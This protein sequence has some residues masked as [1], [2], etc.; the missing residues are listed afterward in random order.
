MIERIGLCKEKQRLL[1][2]LVSNDP[3]GFINEIQDMLIQIIDKEHEDF[4]I[5]KSHSDEKDIIKD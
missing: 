2:K 4:R 3:V 1:I 5:S